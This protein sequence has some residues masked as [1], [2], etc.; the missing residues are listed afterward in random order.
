MG[1]KTFISVKCYSRQL[2]IAEANKYLSGYLANWP[3]ILSGES[4]T[5]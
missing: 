4:Q 1:E 5:N 3:L 2:Q